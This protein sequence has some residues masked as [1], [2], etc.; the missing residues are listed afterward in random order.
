MEGDYMFNKVFYVPLITAFKKDGSVDYAGIK[1]AVRHLKARGAEG[2][3]AMGSSSECFLLTTEERKKGLE[4][5][6]DAR[7]GREVIAHVG[8]PG[9][10]VAANWAKHA[11]K[12]GVHAVAA[13]PPFYHKFSFEEIKAYYRAIAD[14]SDLPVMVYSVSATTGVSLSVNQFAEI[15]EDKRF[16]ALK[17]S[18]KDYFVMERIKAA[19]GVQVFSGA[20]ECFVSAIAAGADGAIGTSMNFMLDK[21]DA[22][23]KNYDNGKTKEAFEGQKKMNTLVMA[24]IQRSSLSNI[25]YLMT[26]QGL[27]IETVSRSPFTQIDGQTKITLKR[28]YEENK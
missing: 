23:K 20:D 12:T 25:K 27:D 21:F 13:V 14:A 16:S 28:L 2:I 22:V 5:V 19:S 17:Y 15:F 9:V 7:V 11:K 24:W 18:D 4:A 8:Y 6:M 1:K 26:L 10:Y 3:Y